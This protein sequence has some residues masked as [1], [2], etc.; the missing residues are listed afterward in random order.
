M[1]N[2][3]QIIAAIREMAAQKDLEQDE[4]NDLIRDGMSAG[5]ARIFGP[6]VRPEITID[7]AAGE[8]D[9]IV[10]KRVVEEVEDP[11]AEISLEKARGTI[12][13]TRWATS[14][15]SRSTL[16]SSDTTPSRP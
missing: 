4:M 1:T 11:S 13:P 14:W 7:E 5:L 2:A 10:L 9:M 8:I 15:R 12:P 3:G 16:P 6:N